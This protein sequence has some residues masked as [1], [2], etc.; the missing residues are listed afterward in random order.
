MYN[1][2]LLAGN[3]VAVSNGTIK[4]FSAVSSVYVCVCVCCYRRGVSAIYHELAEGISS[5]SPCSESEAQA[6]APNHSGH[7]ILPGHM[8]SVSSA[9][10][11]GPHC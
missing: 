10:E 1:A 3:A 5:C 4:M 9:V 11:G 8:A 7:N 6:V 2:S